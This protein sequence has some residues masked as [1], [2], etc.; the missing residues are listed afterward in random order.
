MKIGR[1][2][3][4]TVLRQISAQISLQTTLSSSNRCCRVSKIKFTILI[5]HLKI[6]EV[7]LELISNL[8][9]GSSSQE[10]LSSSMI[11]SIGMTIS[12]RVRK[13]SW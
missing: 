3:I 10:L 13:S 7:L 6:Q 2:I 9:Q 5:L 11:P 1:R 4:W 8:E 12:I